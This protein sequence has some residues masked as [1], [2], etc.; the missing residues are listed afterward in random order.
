MTTERIPFTQPIETRDGSLSKDSRSTNCVFENRDQKREFVKRPGLVAA[1]QVVAVTPPA[2][3]PSQHLVEFNGNL[4][5]V[6]NNTIYKTVPGTWVTSTIGTTSASTT[7]TYSAKTFLSNYLFLQNTVNGYLYTK[8]GVLSTF[9][10]DKVISLSIDAPGIAYSAGITLS[11]S[12]GAASGGVTVDS[13]G[14]IITAV[15]AAG[16]AGYASAPAITIVK[17]GNQT[18]TGTGTT[19]F[20]TITVSSATG[21]FT[22]MAVTGTGIAPN[23]TVTVIN[24]LVLTLSNNNTG[25]VSGTLTFA[26]NG[27]GG[28]ISCALN[29]FPTGPYVPGAVFLDN[30][31]FVGTTGN[32]IYNSNVGDPTTWGALSYL[33]FEQATDNLVAITKHLNYLVAFGGTSTQFFSDVGN[34]TGSPLALAASYTSEIGCASADSVVSTSNTV[35]WIGT[36]K[37]NG[38]SVFIM[39]GISPVPVST[40]SVDKCLEASTLADVNAYV[41]KYNG[42][43]LYILTLHD[44]SQ[45]LV[46]DITAKMW[47]QWTQYSMMSN[48]QGNPGAFQESYFRPTF[49]AKVGNTSYTLDDDT[50]TIYSFSQSVY[51]DNGQSI[52]CR[53]VTDISDN[54][55]TKRKFYGRLEIVGDKTVGTMQIRHTGDDY[56]TWSNYRSIDLSTSRCQIY[57]GGADRRRAW[58]F[59][60]TS[61]CPLR[62]DGAEIDFRLGEMD[63]E[64][65]VGGGRY[66][67]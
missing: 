63:Q 53:A 36:S 21:I 34:A 5:S 55:T 25:A 19:G 33:S 64:Q 62:L 28:A 4:I 37:S 57:L 65:S 51:Q 8:A 7:N 67:G 10:N 46:F 9:A 66:R 54:G 18:P 44:T 61:N 26:D 13:T 47:Y 56:N 27:S 2:F 60:V 48:D 6:I 40:A 20:N 29:S 32:R 3:T 12:T 38:K 49:Y 43:S 17:P 41:Y 31:I 15:L 39:D 42:H 24:A 22:G 16:G 30:Y 14:H 23:T 11:F 52:Y 59:L 50:A 45:T 1:T 35:L 58:E